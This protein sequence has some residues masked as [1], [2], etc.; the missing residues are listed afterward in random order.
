[1][2]PI[3]HEFV[4]VVSIVLTRR[5]HQARFRSDFRDQILIWPN[6]WQATV[7]PI[8]PQVPRPGGP[9][10]LNQ[11]RCRS[12]S[13]PAI[14]WCGART[15]TCIVPVLNAQS[16]RVQS[17]TYDQSDYPTILNFHLNG[18]DAPFKS[19]TSVRGDMRPAA[20]STDVNL[21]RVLAAP[22][23]DCSF[24]TAVA[25]G[26]ILE[27]A[28]DEDLFTQTPPGNF[29]PLM[30]GAFRH[31]SRSCIV[32]AGVTVAVHRC[33]TRNDERLKKMLCYPLYNIPPA[34]SYNCLGL[35]H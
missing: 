5:A 22:G 23:Y 3:A 25:G 29:Y 21:S 30:H 11:Q 32:A 6:L 27:L 2:Q 34:V 31:C 26:A 19:I 12:S 24:V 28:F 15:N 16:Y 35:D 18:H 7:E 1:V 20:S 13:K 8:N 33:S 9:L 4:R 17:V 10:W 14:S